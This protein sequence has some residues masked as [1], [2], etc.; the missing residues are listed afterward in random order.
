MVRLVKRLPRHS[1]FLFISEN[2]FSKI[3]KSPAGRFYIVFATK[4]IISLDEKDMKEV[5]KK[6]THYA[7]ELEQKSIHENKTSSA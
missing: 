4:D 7:F 3:Y 5:S 1:E 6:I 2:D